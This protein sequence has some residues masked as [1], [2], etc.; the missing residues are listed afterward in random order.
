MGLRNEFRTPVRVPGCDLFE[1]S[2][3]NRLDEGILIPVK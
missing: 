1:Q 3:Q 2:N